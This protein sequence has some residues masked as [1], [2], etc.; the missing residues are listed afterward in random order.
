MTDLWKG[1][2]EIL[3]S[4]VYKA[5]VFKTFTVVKVSAISNKK[6][7]DQPFILKYQ[8]FTFLLIIAL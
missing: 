7:E 6:V 3:N 4:R 2:N 5:L 1:N 8:N